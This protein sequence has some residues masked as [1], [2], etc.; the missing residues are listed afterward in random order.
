MFKRTKELRHLA[1]LAAATFV[2]ALTKV[3]PGHKALLATEK[4]APDLAPGTP[5]LVSAVVQPRRLGTAPAPGV[6]TLLSHDFSLAK[7]AG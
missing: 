6:S 7:P 4:N 5:N 1:T 2:P 3:E